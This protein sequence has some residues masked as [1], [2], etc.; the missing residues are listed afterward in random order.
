MTDQNSS[1]LDVGIAELPES[2]WELWRDLRIDALRDAPGAFGETLAQAQARDED[3]WRAHWRHDPPLPRFIATINGAPQ[4]MCSIVLPEDHDFQPLIISMWTSPAARG[5]GL[6]RA[7]L[8]ACVTWCAR[9]G[10]RRLRLGVVEDN[11]AATRL[12][13]GYGFRFDGTGEPLLSDPSKALKWMEL[14]IPAESP[15][16]LLGGQPPIRGESAQPAP[17]PAPTL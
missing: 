2:D 13:L 16:P 14:P 15:S 17:A 8:D 12:Y 7:L 3:G 1:D 6:G 9:T 11:E 4:G 10:R 5:R